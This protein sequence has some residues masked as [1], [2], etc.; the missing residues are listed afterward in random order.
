[1][2]PHELICVCSCSLLTFMSGTKWL[3]R[4]GPQIHETYLPMLLLISKLLEGIGNGLSLIHP[5]DSLKMINLQLSSNA[6]QQ[7][8]LLLIFSRNPFIY[9][10]YIYYWIVLGVEEYA[11]SSSNFTTLLVGHTWK[12]AQMTALQIRNYM[13][14]KLISKPHPI[15]YPVLCTPLLSMNEQEH[16]KHASA[17]GNCLH[18]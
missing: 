9:Y 4:S 7:V 8:S 17:K 6:M 13:Q 12:A 1:M 16:C 18:L 10:C 2:R 14:I 11:S 3:F 15:V 5:Q